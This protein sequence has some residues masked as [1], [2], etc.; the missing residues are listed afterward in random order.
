MDR[1]PARLALLAC[2][3]FWAGCDSVFGSKDDATTDEIF[4]EGS[5]D[6]SQLDEVGYVPLSPFFTQGVGGVFDQPTDVFV[7]YDEFV[8]VADARGIHVLDLAGRP[9]F[10]MD[11][12]TVPGQEAQPLRGIN[13]IVQDR[14]LQLYIAARGDVARTDTL[15]DAGGNVTDVVTTVYPDLPVIYRVSGLTQGLPVVEDV[16][17]H[18][19]DDGSRSGTRFALPGTYARRVNG[20]TVA[21]FTDR[22]AEFTGVAPLADGS[23]YVTRS[24]PVN[25]V[26]D[27]PI[28]GR[29]GDGRPNTTFSPFN[30]LL[31]YSAEGDYIQFIRALRPDATSAG[32][33]SAYYPSDVITFFGPQPGSPVIETNPDFALAQAPAEAPAPNGPLAP[34]RFGVV[35]VDVFEDADGTQYRSDPAYSAGSAD[36]DAPGF[37][38]EENKFSAPTSLAFAPDETRYLFVLDRAQNRLSVFNPRG[39]EGVPP[40]PGSASTSPISVSF[41]RE[42]GGALEFRSPRGVAYYDRTV[43]VADTGNGR[44]SRFRLNTDFE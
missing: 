25:V 33:F 40:P 44:I 41:G 29:S 28:G 12:V 20:D 22:D 9:Q 10:L 2:A 1:F 16:I 3:L 30:A 27:G 26:D 11:Q 38:I 36:A 24:G 35:T 7:G 5:I 4:T 39:V 18:P 13:A 37:L 8:Y 15:R 32:L 6:P 23:I 14:R 17:A 43:Y 34:T 31:R 42:G 19:L 21:V